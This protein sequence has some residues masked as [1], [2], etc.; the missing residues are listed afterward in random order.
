MSILEDSLS[1]KSCQ[2]FLKASMSP[3]TFTGDCT[4]QTVYTLFRAIFQHIPGAS[5]FR[6]K[7]ENAHLALLSGE[8]R[9]MAHH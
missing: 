2:L 1:V 5:M 4:V 9:V 8:S 3:M 6:L 7:T